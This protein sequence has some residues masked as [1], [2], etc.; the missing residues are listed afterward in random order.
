MHLSMLSCGGGGGGGGRVKAGHR[1]GIWRYKS[2][3]GRDIWS[4]VE[5]F[6]T[7]NNNPAWSEEFA[8][9]WPRMTF[10]V[11]GTW[12]EKQIWVQ[13]PRLCPASL[14]PPPPPPPP[15]QLNIGALVL[16]QYKLWM[17]SRFSLITVRASCDSSLLDST[18]IAGSSKYYVKSQANG[19]FNFLQQ[20]LGFNCLC[21]KNRQSFPRKLRQHSITRSNFFGKTLSQTW[22]Y[23]SP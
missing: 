14:P 13:I 15:Q 21:K 17:R 8:L 4:F 7:N 1:R 23:G 2:A 6:L 10:L 22:T 11:P 12:T 19:K 18:E 5:F 16:N 9:F 3:R 20:L